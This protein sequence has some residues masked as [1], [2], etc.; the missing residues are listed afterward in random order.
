MYK[1]FPPPTL[2]RAAIAQNWLERNGEN[3]SIC[4]ANNSPDYSL[5]QDGFAFVD[6]DSDGAYDKIRACVSREGILVFSRILGLAG[7]DVRAV[8]AAGVLES[9]LAM[10]SWR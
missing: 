2:R 8:A 4:D 10:P 7:V 5:F 6:L 1:S 3:K 9:P